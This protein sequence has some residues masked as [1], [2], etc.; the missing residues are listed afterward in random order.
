MEMLV[1][2]FVL[3]RGNVHGIRICIS[4]SANALGEYRD[5]IILSYQQWVKSRADLTL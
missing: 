3:A 1:V 4:Y 2:H 5:R